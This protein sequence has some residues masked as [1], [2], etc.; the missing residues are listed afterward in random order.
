VVN[1][2][3]NPKFQIP[4]KIQILNKIQIPNK[5]QKFISKQPEL[6]YLNSLNFGLCDLS[7]RICLEFGIWNLE[8]K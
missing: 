8:F 5:I 2:I 3:P 1:E 7:F 4:N 6:Q